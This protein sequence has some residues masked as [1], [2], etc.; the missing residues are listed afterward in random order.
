VE[1]GSIKAFS[2]T[3]PFWLSGRSQKTFFRSGH[4]K[5]EEWK[6][7]AALQT[8]KSMRLIWGAVFESSAHATIRRLFSVDGGWREQNLKR[9]VSLFTKME[10]IASGW[11]FQPCGRDFFAFKDLQQQG[12][13]SQYLDWFSNDFIRQSPREMRLPYHGWKQSL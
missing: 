7:A 11:R 5:I 1:I 2:I 4:P 8:C 10:S 9:V 3:S 6:D 13:N 12:K